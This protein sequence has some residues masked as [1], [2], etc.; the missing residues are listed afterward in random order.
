MVDMSHYFLYLVVAASA[1][2][3]VPAAGDERPSRPSVPSEKSRP[4]VDGIKLLGELERLLRAKDADGVRK[5]V[6]ISKFPN[7]QDEL[8]EF[9]D[10]VKQGALADARVVSLEGKVD[11]PVL[12]V[13]AA[14]LRKPDDPR[15][16]V[17]PS[18]FVRR[19]GKLR[20]IHGSP[21][22]AVTIMNGEERAAT[23]R[24]VKWVDQW[25]EANEGTIPEKVR[26]GK[27]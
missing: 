1:L 12:C 5:L 20:L 16:D 17:E 9:A 23:N 15:P 14:F 18:L 3:G 7:A 4:V 21:E 24:L 22:G 13:I 26:G 25:R 27:P 10:A 19:D 6:L 11:G 2:T 8:D